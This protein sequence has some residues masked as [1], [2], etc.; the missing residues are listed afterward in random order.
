MQVHH[1]DSD[2]GNNKDSNLITL[3]IDCH[4]L[5]HTTF[6]YRVEEEVE[7]R[8]NAVEHFLEKDDLGDTLN[9]FKIT[10][11]EFDGAYK[12]YKKIMSL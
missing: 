12:K 4:K 11:G 3:C 7:K 5:F 10:R 9:K 2:G 8:F 1:V 6:D